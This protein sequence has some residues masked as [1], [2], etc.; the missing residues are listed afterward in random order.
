M[1]YKAVTSLSTKH[2]AKEKRIKSMTCDSV[3]MMLGTA[4][5]HVS[6]LLQNTK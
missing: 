5:K 3:I 4:Q 2:I 6:G 1:Q